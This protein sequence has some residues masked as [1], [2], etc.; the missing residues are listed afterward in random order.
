MG[1]ELIKAMA[2]I[3][4]ILGAWLAVQ[5]AW[6]AAFPDATEADALARHGS[7]HGCGCE[8]PCDNS[9]QARRSAQESS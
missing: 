3:A 1:V 6:R 2:G 8:T 7:C 9:K 4:V 5:R